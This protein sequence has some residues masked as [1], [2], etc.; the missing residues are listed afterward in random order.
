MFGSSVVMS[1][2]VTLA[3]LKVQSFTDDQGVTVLE[4]GDGV[5][6]RSQSY[7]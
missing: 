1:R 4:E 6:E 2:P 5:C 3:L 7:P